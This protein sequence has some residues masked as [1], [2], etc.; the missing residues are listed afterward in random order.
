M[1]SPSIKIIDF[2]SACHEQQTLYTYIQSR[3]YRSPE[4]ILGLPYSSAIDMWSLGC[5][6]AELFLGLPIFPG[7]SNYDQI[8]RIV[9]TIGMPPYHMLEVG[10]NVTSFFNRTI[11]PDKKKIYSLKSR[12]QYCREKNVNE[13]VPKRYISQILLADIINNAPMRS[14]MDFAKVE[15]EKKTRI[16][17][18]DFL[19]GLL[20]V[21]PIERWS[22]QQARKHPYLTGEPYNG[23]YVPAIMKPLLAKGKVKEDEDLS[24]EDDER[25]LYE[26]DLDFESPYYQTRGRNPSRNQPNPSPQEISSNVTSQQRRSSA[27]SL[28]GV[29]SKGASSAQTINTGNQKMARKLSVGTNTGR[30]M[31]VQHNN[32]FGSSYQYLSQPNTS[33]LKSS[34]S[35]A[36]HMEDVS[37]SYPDFNMHTVDEAEEHEGNDSQQFAGRTNK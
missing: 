35:K 5:I 9:E 31:S 37:S 11:L 12:E 33:F 29:A 21:N 17:F 13:P 30:R 24:W 25:M 27:P 8:S 23:P 3:F 16:I 34:F 19:K 28:F 15:E 1:D 7:A 36:T 20:N 4:V 26:S 22:P 10:K 6:A 32:G 14:K 2:G 18:L